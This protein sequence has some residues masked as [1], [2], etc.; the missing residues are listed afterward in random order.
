M[1]NNSELHNL[2]ET[3]SRKA[4]QVSKIERSIAI[5]GLAVIAIGLGSAAMTMTAGSGDSNYVVYVSREPC[6]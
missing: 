5:C 2:I 4:M 3:P 6:S 1:R